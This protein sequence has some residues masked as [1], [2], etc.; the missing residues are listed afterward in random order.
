MKLSK[1]NFL[2]VPLSII[3]GMT[4]E[5]LIIRDPQADVVVSNK[6]SR[7]VSYVYVSVSDSTTYVLQD[8]QPEESKHVRIFVSGESL[9]KLRVHLADS[10]LLVCDGRYVET[11]DEV[12]ETV[13]DTGLVVT[14][15]DYFSR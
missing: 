11:G 14:Y 10:S 9:Y 8:I 4:I 7:L 6:S 1:W 13:T 5:L 3:A 2:F 15:G 12:F